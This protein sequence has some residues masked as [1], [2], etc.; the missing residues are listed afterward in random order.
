VRRLSW[1]IAFACLLFVVGWSWLRAN[2]SAATTQTCGA[3]GWDGRF[4]GEQG[5]NGTVYALAKMPSGE[6]IVGGRFTRA[7]NVAVNNIA[8]WHPATG[9]RA[10]S[11]TNG[12]NGVGGVGFAEV[13][14]LSVFGDAVYAGGRFTQAGVGASNALVVNHVACWR[15]RTGWQTL[16]GNANGNGVGGTG[17]TQVYALLAHADDVIVGGNFA[18]VNS[19]GAALAVNS[20][21]RWNRQT[22]WHLLS[23]AGVDGHVTALLFTGEELFVAGS[24][25]RV[26]NGPGTANIAIWRGV[27]GWEPVHGRGGQGV[28]GGG[29]AALAWF[30]NELYVAGDFTEAN[31]GGEAAFSARHV[32]RWNERDGWRTLTDSNGAEGVTGIPHALT[33]TREGVYL[34]GSLARAGADAIANL[35]VWHPARGWQA[36]GAGLDSLAL[37]AL[38]DGCE[39][40]FGGAF[41]SANGQ[42]ANRLARYAA[43]ALVTAT[44]TPTPTPP[45]TATPTPTPTPTPPP[46]GNTPPQ[47]SPVAITRQQGTPGGVITVATVSDA[48][49]PAANLQVQFI[50]A[51]PGLEI[52]DLANVNGS[53]VARITASCTAG[54]GTLTFSLR[55]TDSAGLMATANI[56]VAITANTSPALGNYTASTVPAG[57]NVTL[58]P[59]TGVSDNG[60]I[61]NLVATSPT[62]N[63]TLAVAPVTGMLTVSNARP[64][65]THAIALTVTDNCGLTTTRTLTLQVSRAETTTRLALPAGTYAPNQSIAVTIAVTSNVALG[66]TST[67]GGWVGLFDGVTPLNRTVLDANGSARFTLTIP[68]SGLRELRAQYEGDTQYNASASG[69]TLLG[70]GTTLTAV[71]AASFQGGTLAPE[72]LAAAF[73]AGLSSATLLARTIPLPFVLND[74]VLRVRDSAGVERLAPLL[75]VSP[76]QINFQ[77]PAG[78]ANGT[79]LL[80]LTSVSNRDNL[81]A[82]GS[83]NIGALAPGVFTADGSGTGLAQAQ[84]LRIAANGA[85]SYEPVF[86]YDAAARRFMAVP[87][88]FGAAT[89]QLFLI[90][91]GTGVRG[92]ANLADVTATIADVPVTVLFAGAQGS[93][94][95][96]DQINL[97]L[98]RTL[99][100]KGVVE[101]KLQMHGRAA[102]V[103]QLEFR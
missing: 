19:G 62:F 25:S 53:V 57:G 64:A 21:A 93:L 7:G 36:V 1:R 42:A 49:T 8:R 17:A 22:G 82:S 29:V 77:V 20:I 26:T 97:A 92:R 30:D 44:P 14:A 101:L 43:G 70:A 3:F 55:V 102:N 69:V 34:A 76:L 39:L 54:I 40:Y 38:A 58:T 79:A 94:V 28:S 37:A 90:C 45:P 47:L 50:S 6:L 103:V 5:V 71:S 68:A 75:F 52:A 89:D 10:L 96:V 81:L 31:A 51:M 80:S 73:G 72:Q 99:A 46:Q 12:G 16:N 11:H 78:T 84:V 15:E 32:A 74:L 56:P 87:I 48:Q 9:W 59:T 41:T 33:A 18:E 85:L 13:T 91:F 4:G 86:R 63:G 100:G 95:G 98:P 24:F 67:P 88:S 65:G 61:A 66:T 83:V 60:F 23:N 2:N 27:Q 35:A